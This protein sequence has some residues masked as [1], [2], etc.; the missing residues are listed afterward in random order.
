VNEELQNLFEI[1]LVSVESEFEI[2][3]QAVA[4]L[5]FDLSL[6][7]ILNRRQLVAAI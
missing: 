4:D 1:L 3:G 2:A 6:N 5:Q 7:R